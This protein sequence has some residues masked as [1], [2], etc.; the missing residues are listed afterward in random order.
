MNLLYGI[1]EAVKNFCLPIII[2]IFAFATPLIL[3]TISRVDDK[4]DS[5]LLA[6]LFVR[7]LFCKVFIV[8]MILSFF[9]VFIWMLQIPRLVDCGS[10]NVWVENSASLLILLFTI[11][12]IIASCGIMYLTYIYYI[13]K[14]LTEKLLKQYS[15]H[16]NKRIYFDAV[17]KVLNYS[18]SKADESLA[19]QTYSAINDL[20]I[21]IR[22]G[23]EEQEIVYPDEFYDN[24]FEANEL[25]LKRER[26]TISYI[27]DAAFMS[28]FIDEYHQT[29]ISDK[30]Y[31][32]LWICLRQ[33]VHYKNEEAINAYWERA[34]KY[35][36]VL[37]YKTYP[38]YNLEHKNFNDDEVKEQQCILNKFV[39]FHYA[40]GGLLLY[41]KMH[42]TINYIMNWT[43]SQPPKFNLVLSTMSEVIKMY[44]HFAEKDN[45]CIYPYYETK[46]PFIGLKGV[47]AGD[48][49]S[50]W[51]K[52]YI[53][54]LFIRQY[55]LESYY[56]N[57]NLLQMPVIPSSMKEK[58]LW[59][60]QLDYLK[61]L[62][63]QILDNQVLLT[64]LG[65]EEF[66][67][68]QWFEK[69]KKESPEKLIDS[70]KA[71][72][73]ND[74]E[75]TYKEQ[76]ISNEKTKDFYNATIEVLK[77]IFEQYKKYFYGENMSKDYRRIFALG[78]N[79]LMEK[80]AYVD[81]QEK[82]YGN[83][84]SIVAE[85]AKTEFCNTSLNIFLFMRSKKYILNTQDIWDGVK[86]I[87]D[88]NKDLIIF[89]VGINLNYHK[90]LDP[91]LVISGDKWSYN[92][93]PVVDIDNRGN[94]LVSCSLWIVK[95]EDIPC[96]IFNEITR[97]DIKNKFS[98][99]EI[100]KDYHVYASIVDIYNDDAVRE[101]LNKAKVHNVDK[102]ALVSVCFNAEI[103]CNTKAKAIQLK[104]YSQ[105]GDKE[106]ANSIADL[107]TKWFDTEI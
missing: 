57:D 18:I 71:A 50:F 21:N 36:A 105:F 104:I 91:L 10:L 85:C 97:E 61:N 45:N 64:E 59:N 74:I 40:F 26:K 55:T 42:T 47:N 93:V 54:V 89:S 1:D 62:V 99:E 67:D 100:D 58:K 66:I 28:I 19:R 6:R 25:L 43:D 49:I 7:D 5:T 33:A 31:H 68:K 30:T 11:C 90:E 95:K 9:S 87:C 3:Q 2:G 35:A 53:V 73:E 75:Q 39:E 86:Q 13:P 69:N 82:S 88:K 34:H 94:E 24:V 106:Q 70:Y 12:L 46:Y 29:R 23:K 37:S 27:N 92:E 77:P 8:A 98:L 78:S 107:D 83:A 72:I 51:I 80:D 56:V 48:T 44:M 84:D 79:Q 22:K 103:K 17:C 52:K 41:S 14:R 63:K 65:L 60:K 15:K 101:D 76:P 81:D 32:Y 16:S 96:I 38:K 20:V 102:K 4:Y